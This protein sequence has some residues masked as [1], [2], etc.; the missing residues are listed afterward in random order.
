MTAGDET[1]DNDR[2]GAAQETLRWIA[3]FGRH[4]VPLADVTLD[5]TAPYR[6]KIDTNRR[7]AS[8]PA[9][10]GPTWG[11]VPGR[12]V[13]DVLRVATGWLPVVRR[14]TV[15][16]PLLLDEAPSQHLR[17]RCD[18]KSVELDE[19]IVF[20]GPAGRPIGGFDLAGATNSPDGF[21]TYITGDDARDHFADVALPL[22]LS[23]DVRRGLVLLAFLEVSAI[24]VAACP[25]IP[26]DSTG[27]SVIVLPT[28]ISAA[29]LIARERT[30]LTARLTREVG[31]GRAG[32]GQ[33]RRVVRFA[34]SSK[35]AGSCA[36]VRIRA[37][38]R[39]ARRSAHGT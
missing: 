11:W 13:R 6:I 1:T 33:G 31:S 8:K 17:V 29:L 24:A 2:R 20:S 35:S 32:A 19:G 18:D 16:F 22:R 23:G 39:E 26:L 21:A 27:V 7:M 36:T 4:Y 12:S 34:F 9:W 37:S 15:E 10:T 25:S 28:T 14:T 3:E 5:S 38:R 30:T